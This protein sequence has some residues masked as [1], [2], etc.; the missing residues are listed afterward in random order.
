LL[1]KNIASF[2]FEI[3]GLYEVKL[4]CVRGC[5]E[6]N[7]TGKLGRRSAI[8]VSGMTLPLKMPRQLCGAPFIPRNFVHAQ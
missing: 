4:L 1:V 3:S 7:Y 5:S 6:G 2:D 8:I